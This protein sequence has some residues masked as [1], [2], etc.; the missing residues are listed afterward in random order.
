MIDHFFKLIKN[1]LWIFKY[2][3]L[4]LP[5]QTSSESPIFIVGPPRSGTTI[6]FTSLIS[7]DKFY[8]PNHE[9]GVFLIRNPYTIRMHPMPEKL[10]ER[11]I[12]KA[13]SM[14][15]LIDRAIK[16]FKKNNS[17]Y[18][19]EKTPN[20]CLYFRSIFK[21]FPNARII[22][23][24]RHP[25]D[26][27]GSFITNSSFIPQG[28]SLKASINYWLKCANKI[29]KMQADR[30]V[31]IIRYEDFVS[32]T[33]ILKE[34]ILFL[35]PN[36]KEFMIRKKVTHMYTGKKGFELLDKPFTK[37]RINSYKLI[38]NKNQI[39]KIWNKVEKTACHFGYK[40]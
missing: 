22:V 12:I 6:L 14:A 17:I 23:I 37:R 9:T 33:K 16:W 8:G 32:N 39:D 26:S 19:V 34:V 2:I 29:I 20:H 5:R 10:F 13:K 24:I 7:Y 36:Y 25:L 1:H 31:K 11:N 3:Q 38:F 30:R 18:F 28:K 15:E 27:I 35:D 4:H 40:L 21:T